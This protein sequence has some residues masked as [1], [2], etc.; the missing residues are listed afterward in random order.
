[1][2]VS[3]IVCNPQRDGQSMSALTSPELGGGR[4]PGKRKRYTSAEISW[5]S[6]GRP[7]AQSVK[8]SGRARARAPP[9]R[10]E[11]QGVSR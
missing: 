5:Y 9:A 6:S 7:R 4:N 11:K 8:K 3:Q 10:Y 1:M 2:D